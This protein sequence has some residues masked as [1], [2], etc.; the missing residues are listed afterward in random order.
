MWNDLIKIGWGIRINSSG[1]QAY[2]QEHR[3]KPSQNKSQPG[4]ALACAL[5]SLS[6]MYDVGGVEC[7]AVVL[8]MKYS[9]EIAREC[10]A[11][12]Y[13]WCAK[14]DETT[15][16]SRVFILSVR[17]EHPW[18]STVAPSAKLSVQMEWTSTTWVVD[19]GGDIQYVCM[20]VCI[21][22]AHPVRI[23]LVPA[24]GWGSKLLY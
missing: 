1:W 15:L 21:L 3:E 9:G 8:K 6:C 7:V 12:F 20:Y 2:C 22:Y 5:S 18:E 4:G 17:E 14:S 11:H 16:R 23:S 13:P 19:G 10:G 24:S